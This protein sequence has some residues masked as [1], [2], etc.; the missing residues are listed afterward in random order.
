MREIVAECPISVKVLKDRKTKLEKQKSF[1]RIFSK[2]TGVSVDNLEKMDNNRKNRIIICV[3]S[4]EYHCL[5]VK[6][7]KTY[8]HS[9]G[10]LSQR[11]KI[12]AFLKFNNIKK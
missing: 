7:K 1:D 11:Q 4:S 10:Y 5:C 6:F 12:I 9:I 8:K 2:N 3:N